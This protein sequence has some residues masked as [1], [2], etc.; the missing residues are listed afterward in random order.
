MVNTTFAPGATVSSMMSDDG[1][2]INNVTREA[3]ATCIPGE[4]SFGL[5]NDMQV[6]NYAGII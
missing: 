1:D 6:G 3:V 2:G 4:C 5:Q